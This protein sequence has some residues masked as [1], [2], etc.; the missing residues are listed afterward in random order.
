MIKSL[1]EQED[2]TNYT[3]E[4]HA[5]KN[6]AKQIG[7]ISLSEKAA[8]LEKAG[9]ARDAWMVHTNTDEML[10]QYIAYEPVLAPYCQDE[11]EGAEKAEISAGVLRDCFKAMKVAVDNLDMDQMEEVIREMGQYRYEGWQQGLFDQLREASEEMDV[12]RCEE[13]LLSWEERIES[14]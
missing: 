4:V 3:V 1:E 11:E 9:N 12:D 6:S 2:W 13:I 8:A 7:A 10:E 5:L 14:K